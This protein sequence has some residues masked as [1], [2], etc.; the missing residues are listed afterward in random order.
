MLLVI[1]LLFVQAVSLARSG[2]TQALSALEFTAEDLFDNLVDRAADS[3]YGL[4]AELTKETGSTHAHT[5]GDDAVDAMFVQKTG[6]G[7]RLVTGIFEYFPLDDL[8]VFDGYN[9]KLRA[10][11]EM[12]GNLVSVGG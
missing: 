6:N 12:S 11:P 9:G 1:A 7:A 3:D 5:P 10:S 2:S 4:H 8:S